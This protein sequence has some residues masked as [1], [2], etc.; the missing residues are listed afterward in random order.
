MGQFWWVVV[1]S[2]NG[3]QD[4]QEVHVSRLLGPKYMAEVLRCDCVDLDEE[5]RLLSAI[6]QGMFRGGYEI[7]RT[8][9]G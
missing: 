8:G 7:Q 9:L 3:P 6:V 4:E 5:P 1:I 2:I